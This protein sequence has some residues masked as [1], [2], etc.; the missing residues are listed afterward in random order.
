MK[1]FVGYQKLDQRLPLSSVGEE[2]FSLDGK[3]LWV[4]KVSTTSQGVEVTIATDED[5]LLDG[6]TIET[7][8]ETTSLR[9][10]VNQI[11]TKLDD[12]TILKERTLLFDTQ[13]EPEY[14]HIKG[15]HY[16]KVYNEVIEIPVD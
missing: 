12:G 2:P 14:L 9:T 10:T 6:V 11:E 5:I 3:E 8:T 4:K 15:M 16:M 13:A 1:E 7:Q